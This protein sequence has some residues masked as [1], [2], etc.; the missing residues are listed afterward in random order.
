[1]S[2]TKLSWIQETNEL[3]TSLSKMK[4][5]DRE[6]KVFKVRHQGN[7]AIGFHLKTRSKMFLIFL[8]DTYS[9]V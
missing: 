5:T 1:M 6:H 7:P 4:E 9:S 3:E 8:S 2:S